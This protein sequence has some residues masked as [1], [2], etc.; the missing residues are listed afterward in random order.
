M[1][2]TVDDPVHVRLR[3]PTE[4]APGS[5]AYDS[6]PDQFLWRG[7]LYLVRTV[8]GFWRE[9]QAWWSR[10]AALAAHGLGGAAV[11]ADVD[12]V[13]CAAADREIWRVEAGRGRLGTAG[14]YDLCRDL[15]V[16]EGSWRLMRVCD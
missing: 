16:A 8:L 9:R 1:T 2:R 6:Q 3:P 13:A 5:G 14:V 4:V 11:L 15:T 7:R 12:R 10:P